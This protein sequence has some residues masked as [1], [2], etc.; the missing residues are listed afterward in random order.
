[1]KAPMAR[2]GGYRGVGKLKI[3]LSCPKEPIREQLLS[4]KTILLSSTN[5]NKPERWNPPNGS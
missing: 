4:A 1:M 3:Q 2:A 5:S